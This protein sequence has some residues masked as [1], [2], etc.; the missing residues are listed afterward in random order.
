MTMMGSIPIPNT[1][2]YLTSIDGKKWFVTEY[3]RTAP[4]NPDKETYDL[5]KAFAEAFRKNEREEREFPEELK[6]A[7]N[8]AYG[9][10]FYAGRRSEL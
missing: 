9:N 2:F 8:K 4:F 6:N 7:V 5:Y 1:R 3:Y 10:G